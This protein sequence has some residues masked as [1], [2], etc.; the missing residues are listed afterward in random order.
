MT[1]RAAFAVGGLLGL[2][3]VGAS[4][5]RTLTRARRAGHL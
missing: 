4:F 5:A 1:N 3:L 2:I